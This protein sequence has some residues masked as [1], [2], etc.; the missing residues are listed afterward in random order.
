VKDERE[1]IEDKNKRKGNSVRKGEKKA[2]KKT[3]LEGKWRSL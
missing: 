3:I 1:Q 2:V